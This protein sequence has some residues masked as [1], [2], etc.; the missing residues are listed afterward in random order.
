MDDVLLNKAASIERCVERIRQ[1]YAGDSRNLHEDLTRQ[2]SILLNLQ[3]AVE[4]AIDTAM[5]VVRDQRLGVPQASRDAF[6]LLSAAGALDGD[7]ADRM[8]RMVGFRNV[9]VHAYQ[10]IDLD[11]VER[12]VTSHLDDLLALARW[13]IARAAGPA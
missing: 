12:I 10:K 9:A 1:V 7:L 4:A 2:D 5:H 11:I 8:K 3:R 13:A 6:D